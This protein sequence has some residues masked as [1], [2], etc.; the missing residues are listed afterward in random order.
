LVIPFL[1]ARRSTTVLGGPECRRHASRIRV[2]R[3]SKRRRPE[4]RDAAGDGQLVIEPPPGALAGIVVRA[5]GKFFDVQLRD[6]PRTLLATV[7]G[8]VRRERRRSDLVAVGDRVW[9]TDVGEGEGQIEAVEPRDRVLARLARLTED[10]E[11]VILA[12]L[13][14]AMFLF[15][16]RD[17]S[18]HPRMLD[19]FL[20]MA[21]SRNL[22]A[23]IGVS[24]MDLDQPTGR[25]GEMLSKHLFGPY[26]VVYPVF[27]LSTVTGEGIESLREAIAGKVT[28]VAGPSGVGKSSLLN[29]LD[30]ERA[31]ETASVSGATG[32]GRHTT[33][34]TE[35]LRIPGMGET[36][37]AD[38]PGIRSLA[39]HG[40]APEELDHCFPEFRPF[41]GTCFYPDCTHLHEPDCAVR[42][43]VAE[44]LIPAVRY[45][46]Y[47]ILRRGEDG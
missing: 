46:S 2:S 26:E 21:E 10:V 44:G 39:L 37:L 27:Y 32:K 40:V 29:V 34:A 6:E 47:A 31:R 8:T 12:N 5:Y 7:R 22:P 1:L 18:P 14:Q 38:T 35:L 33:I 13:D 9:V 16:V 41:L 42:R 23:M 43:A 11:Q 19:R 3:P 45:E 4:R 36:Y 17:P 24:K 20:V 15:S 30:P 28:A 25:S